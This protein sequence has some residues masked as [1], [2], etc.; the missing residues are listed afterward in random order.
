M[1]YQSEITS[2]AVKRKHNVA[3][4]SFELTQ[5]VQESRAIWTGHCF[6]VSRQMIS[7]YLVKSDLTISIRLAI[8]PFDAETFIKIKK[9]EMLY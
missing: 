8:M 6:H 7:A 4:I 9:L 5:K 3:V 2:S 1:L